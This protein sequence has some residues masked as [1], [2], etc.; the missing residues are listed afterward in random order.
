MDAAE[1][2]SPDT[3]LA[4]FRRSPLRRG[5]GMTTTPPHRTLDPWAEDLF[6][7]LATTFLI[8]VRFGELGDGVTQKRTGRRLSRS[9]SI[10]RIGRV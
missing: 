7:A 6:I 10:R 2:A 8:A 3:G 4:K 9:D 5:R 1:P